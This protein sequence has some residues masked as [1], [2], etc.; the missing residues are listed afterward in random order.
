[1][2]LHVNN[3]AYVD[4]DADVLREGVGRMRTDADK[5][6][7]GQNR[8]IFLRTSF[9][10]DPQGFS[11]RMFLLTSSNINQVSDKGI[12]AEIW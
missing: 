2:Q 11:D 3:R 8:P 10:H 6:V 9:V 5:G 12:D 1:M 7:G 4:M